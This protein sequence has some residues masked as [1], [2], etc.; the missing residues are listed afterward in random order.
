ML[1]NRIISGSSR[2]G[3][4]PPRLLYRILDA[5][6][7]KFKLYEA[8]ALVGEMQSSDA[9]TVAARQHARI[10]DAALRMALES[11][12]VHAPGNVGAESSASL[13]RPALPGT[14]GGVRAG[15]GY[16]MRCKR[17]NGPSLP[18]AAPRPVSAARPVSAEVGVRTRELHR[19]MTFLRGRATT[20]RPLHQALHQNFVYAVPSPLPRERQPA[21]GRVG[22]FRARLEK[23][24]E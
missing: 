18:V 1:A 15:G 24:V 13:H 14:T 21:R 5:K 22:C 8:P 10:Q 11:R 20:P 12:P 9:V 19:Y 6:K 17:V 3:P 2:N 7:S 4:E 23:A 16:F